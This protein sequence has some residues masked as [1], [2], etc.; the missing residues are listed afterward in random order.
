MDK[1]KLKKSLLI[2]SC[3]DHIGGIFGEILLKFFLKEE[4][5]ELNENDYIYSNNF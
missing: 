4:L 5:I 3:H 1:V 2:S